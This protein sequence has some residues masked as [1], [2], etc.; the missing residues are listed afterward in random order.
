M[1]PLAPEL[2]ADVAPTRR[3]P[4]V[5]VPAPARV[6][7]APR[8]PRPISLALQGGGALGAY[9]WGV[10]EALLARPDLPIDLVSGTSAG[11]LNGAVLAS[12][13]ASGGRRHARDAL[14]SF[15]RSVAAPPSQ[16]LFR[17]MMGPVGGMVT[18][19][20]RQ[21]LFGGAMLS[22]YQTDPL[23][24]NPLRQA[25]AAHVDVEALRA[26]RGPQLFVTATHVRTGLPR[27]FGGAE[28]SIDALLASAC[29]PQLF[30]AV[31]VDGEPY[32]DGGYVGN[33]TLWPLVRHGRARDLVLVQL[34]PDRR[35]AL[36]RSNAAIRQRAAEIVFNSSL[37]A[38]MQAIQ[39]L[40]ELSP[41]DAT[42]GGTGSPFHA[43]RFHRLGPPPAEV[44]ERPGASLDR[45][46]EWISALRDAGRD[47]TRRFLRRDGPKLGRTST[48]DIGQ[49]YGIGRKPRIH[50]PAGDTLEARP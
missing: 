42:P 29:L 25:I 44:L 16:S 9:T 3:D 11:A 31:E 20:V 17:A 43:I 36:P 26:R 18:E 33:P 21:W 37:V 1:D 39:A 6:V 27:V 15:W 45:S 22:P 10:L 48:L 32:W 13:L 8:D 7:R 30:R 4:E 46:W 14:E 24:L 28:I 41:A 38:E 12:A 5:S 23:D 19:G 40:R 50:L 49:A 34:A 47:A 35:D 2:D